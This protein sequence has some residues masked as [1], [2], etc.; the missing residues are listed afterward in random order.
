M[1]AGEH[2]DSAV[3]PGGGSQS[4]PWSVLLARAL[5]LMDRTFGK[6]RAKEP[7]DPG[8]VALAYAPARVNLIGDHTDYQG[9]LALPMALPQGALAMARRRKDGWVGVVSEGRGGPVWR[10]TEQLLGTRAQWDAWSFRVSGDGSPAEY[11][12]LPG[13]AAFLSGC[14]AEAGALDPSAG[15]VVRG[16]DI[17][18][19]SDVSEGKGLSSSAAAGLA[20]ALAGLLVD[21][22]RG[23]RDGVIGAE[24]RRGLCFAVQ[25]AE[26]RYLAVPSGLLDELAC[27]FAQPGHALLVDARA[28]SAKPVPFAP[29]TDGAGIAIIDVGV[30]R[31]LA[32][33]G[34]AARR[35]EVEEAA[36]RLGVSLLRDLEREDLPTARRALP[37]ALYLRVRHVV[38]ENDRVRQV[39][40]LASER[41]W[42]D[43]GDLMIESHRSLETDY[44][45]SH[46]VLDRVVD[47]LSRGEPRVFARVT[48]GGFGGNLVAL[49]LGLG[50]EGIEHRLREAGFGV[51]SETVQIVR[52][53]PGLSRIAAS[54][55]GRGDD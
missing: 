48:G 7:D 33:S 32:A 53:G 2:G 50:R 19:A 3:M 51:G 42:R 14:I 5:S 27:A 16:L 22:R 54:D 35:R 46:P 23:E 1:R 34:Y 4:E 55:G 12:L 13:W 8:A 37:N 25:R 30:G 18:L 52:A 41:R 17:A 44:G 39:A 38:T 31:Q 24:V 45:S 47:V 9:G 10:T 11:D 49:D 28:V 15:G 29:E 43:V 20:T 26:H 36:R 21:E 6:A 40:R